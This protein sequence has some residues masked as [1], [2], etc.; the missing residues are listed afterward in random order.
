MESRAF[1]SNVKGIATMKIQAYTIQL[2]AGREIP[3]EARSGMSIA[4]PSLG[5]V[6]RFGS[7]GDVSAVFE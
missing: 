7:Q 1:W 6:K 2:V 3:T 5:L 4:S